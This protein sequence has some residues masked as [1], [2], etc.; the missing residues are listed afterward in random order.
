MAPNRQHMHRTLSQW[1]LRLFIL[2]WLTSPALCSP[3]EARLYHDLFTSYNKYVRPVVNASDT[4]QVNVDLSIIDIRDLDFE[5]GVLD[6]ISWVSLTWTD[7]LLKWSPGEYEGVNYLNVPSETTWVP[8]IVISNLVSSPVEL[9]PSRLV[10]SSDGRVLLVKMYRTRTLCRSHGDLP[11]HACVVKFMS[12]TYNGFQ[13]NVE[14]ERTEVNLN[15]YIINEQWKII[16]RNMTRNVAFYSCCPESYPSVTAEIILAP[17]REKMR[18]DAVSNAPQHFPADKL[19]YV[20]CMIFL[21]P[22]MRIF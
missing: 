14:S 8:D 20:L 21:S 13:V 12:W 22:M 15:E 4:I 6:M 5:E 9:S 10:V 19:C 3:S 17:K 18:D 16:E 11:K 1:P 2:A 7:H